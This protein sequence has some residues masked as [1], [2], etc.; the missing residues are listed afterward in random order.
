MMHLWD[1]QGNEDR[2][3]RSSR[4]SGGQ[5][6]QNWR[7]APRRLISAAIVLA[8][9]L[10]TAH[11]E[12]PA[13][14]PSQEPTIAAASVPWLL[15]DWGGHRT[16]LQQKGIDLQV[17]YTSETAANTRGGTDKKAAYTD[18]WTFGTTLDLDRLLGVHDAR[19]QITITDRNGS[20][21]SSE[22]DLGTLQ[23]VQEVFGR[24]QTWRLTQFWY[25]QKYFDGLLDWKAGRLGVGE[26]FASF[27]C[28]FQ[29]LTFCGSDPGNLVGNYIFNWPVSQW[30]TRLKVAIEG[31]GYAQIGAY[32]VNPKYLNTDAEDA[33][34]PVFLSD[35][36]GVLLPVEVAWLPEFANGT[37]PGSYKF[38]VWVDTS[39]ATDVVNDLGTVAATNPGVPV[40]HDRGRFGGYINFEQQITRT[41]TANPEGGL[42]LFLNAVFADD[43]TATTDRQIA[44]GFLYTGPFPSRPDDDVAFAVGTTHVN[45][46][47]AD[48][49]RLENSIGLGPTPVQH[50]EYVFELYYTLHPVSGLLFRPN[51]QYVRN[52][53]GTTDNEDAVVMGLKIVANF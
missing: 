40:D 46:R 3:R 26:D 43:R 13:G 39:D 35:S 27:A 14:K 11:A 6:G 22:A 49:Q 9:L 44:G 25:D 1:L 10:A 36:T 5:S 15:G 20:N 52:P 33:L 18:Q 7:T 50:S 30:A 42:R 24:G 29:N 19:F 51:L 45:D 16:R 48:A 2:S 28:D 32:D 8:A 17:G 21:L 4:P 37:L 41:A 47:V 34:L 53:G 38:G 31:F 23:Q 12:D